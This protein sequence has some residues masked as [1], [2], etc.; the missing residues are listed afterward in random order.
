MRYTLMIPGPV[1]IPEKILR[2]CEGQPVA[3]YGPEWA[4]LYIK[5]AD[6]VSKILGSGG[7]SFLMP[8]SGS[9]G[10]DSAAATFCRDKRCLVVNN[11]MFG[12]RISSIVSKQAEK[13]GVLEFP[14]GKAADP[15]GILEALEKGEYDVLFM[16]HVE[17]S[18]GVLNPVSEIGRAV[19]Q[20]GA[21]FILDAVSSAA[22]ER[23]EMDDWGIGVCVTASQKGF[24]SPAGLG[25][26]TVSDALLSSLS[27][28]GGRTWYTNL[29]V[30]WD[31]YNK[32]NDWHPFPVTLPTQTIVGLAKSLDMIHEEGVQTR[33]AMYRTVAGKVRS[34]MRALGLKPFAPDEECAHGLT[35]VSTDGK[36]DPSRL[37]DYLKKFFSIQI[38]G[39]FGS[40]KDHVFRVGHMSRPQCEMKNL[41]AF[42]TGVA[43]FM[44]EEGVPVSPQDALAEL[45]QPLIGDGG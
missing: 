25:I 32:W 26:V 33:Q 11:G 24:E 22:I 31:F 15:D 38:S 42:V 7:K 18:T 10:L 12:E 39:S 8:G 6:M 27:E 23:L 3:H 17:T 45:T 2:A 5:T 35:A 40:L 14:L 13:V 19:K 9:L 1:E 29:G 4:K 43:Q 37:V 30:W 28:S 34:A 21:L 16:T 44:K 20:T 41:V 36:I